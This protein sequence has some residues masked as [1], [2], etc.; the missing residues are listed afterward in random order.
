MLAFPHNFISNFNYQSGLAPI[1]LKLID[2]AIALG[3]KRSWTKE[4]LK[5]RTCGAHYYVYSL[6]DIFQRIT[7]TKVRGK[8]QR[9]GIIS[10]V[11]IQTDSDHSNSFQINYQQAVNL[12]YIT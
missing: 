4:K 1:S 9:S 2:S 11:T 12:L 7:H 3:G 6:P 5:K 10:H 8:C